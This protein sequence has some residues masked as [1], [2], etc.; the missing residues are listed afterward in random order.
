MGCG[1]YVKDEAKTR[2]GKFAIQIGRSASMEEVVGTLAVEEVGGN[3]VISVVSRFRRN[4]ALHEFIPQALL[5][6]KVRA[7]WDGRSLV[8]EEAK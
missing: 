4:H 5:N 6:K 1:H 2:K 8:I 7:R 3:Y